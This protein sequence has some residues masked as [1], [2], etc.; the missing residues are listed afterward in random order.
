[1]AA[2]WG[3]YTFSS[4]NG[5]EGVR[6]DVGS[7]RVEQRMDGFSGTDGVI[8]TVFGTR[9]RNIRMTCWAK[10]AN[11]ITLTGKVGTSGEIELPVGTKIANMLLMEVTGGD[12][13][14]VGSDQYC[15]L[16]LTWVG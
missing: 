10:E 1:M 6:F 2:G 8:V 11:R 12:Y 4:G 16:R 15:I 14:L 9:E 5:Y 13:F 3:T 7:P